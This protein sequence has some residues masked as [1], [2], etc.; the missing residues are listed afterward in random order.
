MVDFNNAS[1][2]GAKPYFTCSVT[3][4]NPYKVDT[5]EDML[6]VDG[7][8]EHKVMYGPL[9]I[10]RKVSRILKNTNGREVSLSKQK[11]ILNNFEYVFPFC[12]FCILITTS[13][14]LPC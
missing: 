5:Y 6:D 8:T 2:S 3:T 7:F 10:W 14:F 9:A 1:S 13:F 4:I 11:P 12:W